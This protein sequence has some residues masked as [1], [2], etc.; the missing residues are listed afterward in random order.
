MNLL[1]S[2]K[3]RELLICLCKQFKLELAR[4]YKNTHLKSELDYVI[5]GNGVIFDDFKIKKSPSDHNLILWDIQI[6]IPKLKPYLKLP[7]RKL[8]NH[9][10]IKA[11]L[12]SK[13]ATQFLT[14][15]ARSRKALKN[16]IFIKIK[17]KKIQKPNIE[18]LLK[19]NEDCD[20]IEIIRDYWENFNKEIENQRF[21]TLSKPLFRYLNN[22]FKYKGLC[23]RD[24]SI[25]SS[26]YND[27]GEF[28]SDP[29]EVAVEIMKTMNELQSNPEEIYPSKLL[30]PKL[31]NI[32]IDYIINKMWN[33]KALSTD[34]VSDEMFNP[35]Y[36]E[37]TA[38]VLRNLWNTDLNKLN[39]SHF[40]CRLIPLNKKHPNIPTRKDV[41]PIIVMS[42][43]LKLLES[44]LLEDL[45]TYLVKE[46]HPSQTGFVPG[47]GIFVNIH[48]AIARI[49]ARTDVK[50]KC[51]GLF[52]D[53]SSAYNTINH[54]KLFQRL[55]PIIGNEKTKFLKAIYSRIQI[56]LESQKIRPNQGVAQGS[57]ISPALFD[58]YTEELLSQIERINHINLEDILS[59]ADDL[60][61]IC[62][63][64]NQLR[65]VIKTVKEW[66]LEN[67]LKLNMSKS[68]IVEFCHRNQRNSKLPNEIENIP[69]L[70]DYK[71]LGLKLDSKL[72]MKSQILYKE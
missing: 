65:A 72:T 69:V 25:V 16:K 24:G 68:G 23:Q 46:L 59:Y 8:A 27:N 7:N 61:I 66:S 17:H 12:Q 45:M 5:H 21:S 33:G 40:N 50:K 2:S 70:Q 19:M 54:Q 30:F 42:P 31:P 43:L 58:I 18:T 35:V 32:N 4:T 38:Y 3:K 62:D 41:R 9:V 22:A 10:T 57:M 39:Q 71:Y 20:A 53:F 15:I 56:M 36:K 11:L 14:H 1:N 52:F 6:P 13:N 63:N 48:R 44:G 51:Y 55:L 29:E 47:N 37:K 49:K 67:N 60:L 26:L 34:F 28:I 64:V